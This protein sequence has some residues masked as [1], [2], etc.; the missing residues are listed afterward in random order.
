MYMLAYVP[1]LW[2]RIM[3][4]RLMEL[5]HVDGDLDKVNIDAAAHPSIFLKWGREKMSE[6]TYTDL[7]GP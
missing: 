3:D 6:P 1:W 4:K 7:P 2:F 5:P